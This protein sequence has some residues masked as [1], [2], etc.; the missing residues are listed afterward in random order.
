MASLNEKS[1][2]NDSSTHPSV[3]S[4]ILDTE[5]RILPETAPTTTYLHNELD[6]EGARGKKENEESAS[7][8][9]LPP[10][11]PAA[12]PLSSSS[13]PGGIDPSSFP[14]GGF[15]AWLVVLG[16]FCCLIVSF[17]WINCIGVFQE[18]YQTHQLRDYSPSTI[19]WIPS[20][21]TFMMFA[22]GP[23][24]GKLYDNHGPRWILLFGTFMHVFGLMMASISTRYYQFV[25]AQGI[26]SA[27]GASAIFYSATSVIPTWFFKN[28]ALAFGIVAS[29]S[30]L[31]G[32]IFPIMVERLVVRIGFGWTMRTTA[33]LILSL[34]LIANLTVKSRLA[35]TPKPLVIAEF[36]RPLK[37][38]PFLLTCI[39][40][41]LFFWGLFLPL[42]FII[43]QARSSVGMSSHLAGYLLAILNATSLFGRILPGYIA[44]HVGRFNVMIVTSYFSAIVVLAVWLPANSNAAIIVFAALFGFGSG[45]FVSLVPALVAQIS[46]V[47]MIGVRTGTLFAIISTAALFGNPVGGRLVTHNHGDFWGLQVFAGTMMAAG[48]TFFLAARVKLAGWSVARKV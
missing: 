43:S 36:L 29:G 2:L 16:S 9:S 6:L 34:L 33:F 26:C 41:Y 39:A 1:F 20:L 31:G 12:Q 4:F 32:V 14:D 38:P 21:E 22:G 44:D 28:R 19:A 45:S 25:L 3:D 40:S 8:S 18:Y 24:F 7:S 48:S 42:N 11:A 5:A 30:S 37:E 17:G 47:R 15:E 10:A 13:Q 23:I 46:D 35:P 27:L